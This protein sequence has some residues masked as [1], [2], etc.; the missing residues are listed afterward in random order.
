MAISNPDIAGYKP[1]YIQVGGM[2][3][4]TRERWGFIAKTNPYPALPN[5][6]D[7]YKNDWPDEHGD[8]EYVTH[9]YYES[10]E[11]DVQFYV[12]ATDV[13]SIRT[14]LT[15]FFSTIRDGEFS[16]Y[17]SATGLGRRKVRYAGFKEER[18][19][20]LQG[21]YARCIFTVTFKVNDSV[22]FMTYHDHGIVPVGQSITVIDYDNIAVI[23]YPAYFD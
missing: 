2:C 20:V 17:D 6:K 14:A 8:D 13:D 12:R 4:D 22:T 11:F 23:G 5:P 18:A 7:P 21:G 19:P 1:F 9:L 16:V 10:F 15:S 3:Y